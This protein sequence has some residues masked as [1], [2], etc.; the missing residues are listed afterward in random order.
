MIA[1]HGPA[2]C[3][4]NLAELV[5]TKRCVGATACCAAIDYGPSPVR[6]RAMSASMSSC[7]PTRPRRPASSSSA[8]VD[9]EALGRRLGMPQEAGVHAGVSQ[10]QR[11]TV[12]ADRALLQ[13]AD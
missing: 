7:P 3:L 9:I 11:L 8:R 4:V 2:L 12:H 13:R 1:A 5:L 10:G 6:S